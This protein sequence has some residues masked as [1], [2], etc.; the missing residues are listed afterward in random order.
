MLEALRR[1]EAEVRAIETSDLG[2]QVIAALGDKEQGADGAKTRPY[3][4]N[5]RSRC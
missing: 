2:N 4:V 3:S 5:K 1:V